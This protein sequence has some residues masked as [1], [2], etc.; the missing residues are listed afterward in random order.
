M[1]LKLLGRQRVTR[2]VFSKYSS[3]K[4]NI[5]ENV[6]L[7]MN[8]A[9]ELVT[10]VIEVLWISAIKLIRGRR[11]WKTERYWEICS[12]SISRREG[13]GKALFLSTVTWSE[14]IEKMQLEPSRRGTMTG[15]EAMGISWNMSTSDQ[16]LGKERG[17]IKHWSRLPR[18]D[19]KHLFLEA[20]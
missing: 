2:I 20:F 16:I 8:W 3:I 15:Q 10:G 9:E 11:I 6:G 12:C 19:R 5:W 17:T 13:S 7:L 1:G 14:D 4:K 18:E